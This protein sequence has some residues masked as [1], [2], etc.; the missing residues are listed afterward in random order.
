MSQSSKPNIRRLELV[1]SKSAAK[2]PQYMHRRGDMLYFKRKI[3]ADV[4]EAFPGYKEQVWKSLET[5]LLSKAK[6]RLEVEMTEF[7]LALATFRRKKAAQDFEQVDELARPGPTLI[8]SRPAAVCA[9]PQAEPETIPAGAPAPAAQVA[10]TAPAPTFP[11]A[12]VSAPPQLTEL[13][14]V[15]LE[16]QREAERKELILSLE[17]G[18]E[19]L[20]QMTAGPALSVAPSIAVVPTQQPTKVA[21]SV[22]KELTGPQQTMLHLFEDWKR[23]QSRHRT[24]NAV[25]TAVLEFRGLHGSI[26]VDS[27]TR[28]MARAYRDKLM[29]QRLRGAF[30]T[31][32]T[33]EQAPAPIKTAL[34]VWYRQRARE[35]FAD[36]LVAVAAPLRWVKQVPPTRLRSMTFCVFDGSTA[37]TVARA[38]TLNYWTLQYNVLHH[39]DISQADSSRADQ[40]SV[41]RAQRPR[42]RGESGQRLYPARSLAWRGAACAAAGVQGL[43][44]TDGIRACASG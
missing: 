20:R 39:A 34:D 8:A 29:E 30:I 14:A 27:I 26:P 44:Q 2:L 42:A 25:E 21:P 4:A 10:A 6:V 23:I 24:I 15:T 43:G 3:P 19:Q 22:A 36:R 11:A 37:T 12:W 32:T 35:V 33:P 31:V 28:L 9:E 40:A 18:L 16:T 7:N 41:S 38:D 17:A 5:N 1:G 13:A